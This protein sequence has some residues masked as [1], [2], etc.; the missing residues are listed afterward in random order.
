GR[1][2][3]GT[4]AAGRS[5]SI[6]QGDCRRA[7]HH[8]TDGAMARVQGPAEADECP[9][10][11]IAT[12]P[13]GT[14]SELAMNC[15]L[16]RNRIL[17]V[18]EPDDLPEELAG[19]IERCADCKAWHLNFVSVDRALASL[20]VAPS[21]GLAKI[22]LLEQVRATPVPASPKPPPTP[23]PVA[24]KPARLPVSSS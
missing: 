13:A 23:A 18:E 7:G 2:S 10:A 19:H 22:A 24:E 16:A 20:P 9:G 11:R 14:Q 5:G 4:V 1:L 15:Q 6:V 3:L 12:A 21:D 17:A 8:G